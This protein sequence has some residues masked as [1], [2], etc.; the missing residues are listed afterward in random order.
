M[1]IPA[2]NEFRGDRIVEFDG[3]RGIAALAVLLFHF[4]YL[5]DPYPGSNFQLP[6]GHYGV[7]LFMVISGF[8]IFMNL[9]KSPGIGSFAWA[10]V[11]RLFPAYWACAILT[12]LTAL[13]LE[14]EGPSLG[15][16]VSNLSM[17]QVFVRKANLDDSYW[18]LAIELCFYV[19]IAILF[20]LRLARRFEICALIWAAAMVFA[21]FL[22]EIYQFRIVRFVRDL[23][24]MN[25]GQFF[26]LG[27]CLYRVAAKEASALTWVVVCVSFLMSLSGGYDSSMNAPPLEY[28]AATIMIFLVC[29]LAVFG[30]PSW[31]RSLPL[32]FLGDIS[33]PL[34]LLHQRIGKDLLAQ[35]HSLEFPRLVALLTSIA[36]LVGVAFLV[37][38]FVE[39]PGRLWI[40]GRFMKSHP[41]VA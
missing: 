7:E 29:A 12:A 31:L 15:K 8:V 18:S 35:A 21:Q 6:W 4:T 36:F 32:R 2:I 14:A 39:V 33:F 20:R 19:A 3:L 5:N 9:S 27:I 38:K 24:L 41:V 28:F 16:V 25:Y 1:R 22:G 40:R 17:L 30:K 23:T 34:Y 11:A 10:R 26:V 37:H 13:A